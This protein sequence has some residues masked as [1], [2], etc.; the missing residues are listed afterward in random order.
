MDINMVIRELPQDEWHRLLDLPIGENGLP[1]P[2]VLVVV[3][4]DDKNDIV[5]VWT[6]GPIM[7]LEGLWVH[8]DHQKKTALYRI[9][10]F[11]IKHLRGL[12]I[13]AVFSIVQTE[14][15]AQLAAHGG[16]KP[17]DGQLIVLNLGDN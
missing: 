17:L 11:M 12:G 14:E 16:F 5:G 6:A 7:V 10:D 1:S 13:P 8:P 15:M 2:D 4:E 9:F 3:A